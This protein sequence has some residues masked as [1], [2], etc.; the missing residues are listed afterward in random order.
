M[1]GVLFF[2]FLAGGVSMAAFAQ[3]ASPAI[4][5]QDTLFLADPTI[6]ADKG[7]YYLYGTGSNNGFQVY[8]SA[9]LK[10]WSAP[11]G[12]RNGFALLKGESYGTRGFWAPQIFKYR[13][14]YYMAYTADEHIAIAQSDSPLGPFTQK[15]IRPLSGPVKQIDPFIFIENG[16]A[17]LYHVRLTNGNRIFVAP[18]K[19][20]LSDVE[21]GEAVECISGTQP[22]EN[23]ANAGWPVTEGP[24]VIKHNK[25]YYLFYSANDFRNIDYAMGY[26]TS[27]SPLG[28]WKKYRG[29]PVIS[30]N[31]LNVN[32]TGHGDFFT[33][34]DGTL[35]YVFHVHRSQTKVSPRATVL[36]KAK[37]TKEKGQPDKL[38]IDPSS[39]SY[40]RT[41]LLSN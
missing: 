14:L 10:T 3:S 30:R 39:F 37:F 8:T 26:A 11:A 20:D 34:N 16:K 38:T 35:S 32:G 19:S 9:D 33:A 25:L 23:T 6:F 28:P 5:K 21:A 12:K 24:T 4:E 13:N 29:N 36:I 22:W 1:R 17:Y 41:G 2:L 7:T 31:V 18:M 27:A 15:E 40:L